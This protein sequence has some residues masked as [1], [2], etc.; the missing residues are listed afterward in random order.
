LFKSLVFDKQIAQ[1]VS[2]FQYSAR[3]AGSFIIISTA[4][5]GIELTEIK[6]EIFE[7][8]HDLIDN[9][10]TEDE[11][12]KAR[13]GFKSSFIYSLQKLDTIVDHMNH[14]NFYLDEPNS[15]TF[16]LARYEKVTPK[17][18]SD[19]A[20]KYL[21]NPFVELNIIPKASRA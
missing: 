16:D 19:V 17:N 8:I 9:G 20:A 1:D 14:Y 11:L 10:V 4:K 5:P 3:L 2:A 7:R 18:I 15:F 12:L 13:N 21:L 6:K